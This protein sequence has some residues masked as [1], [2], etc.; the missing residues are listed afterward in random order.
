MTEKVVELMMAQALVVV[1]AEIIGNG[2]GIGSGGSDDRN[3]G[4]S[5]S[6]TES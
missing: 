4:E 5:Y 3:S 6:V 2:N 1:A